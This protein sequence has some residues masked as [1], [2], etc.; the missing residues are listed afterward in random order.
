MLT[1]DLRMSYEF[2]LANESQA[3]EIAA[4]VNSAY[5]GDHSRHGWTT[6]ADLLGG[7]RTDGDAVQAM[8]VEENSQI[9][10]AVEGDKR[11]IRGCAYVRQEDGR[12]YVGMLT[13]EP[14]LQGRG[15]GRLLLQEIEEWVSQRQCAVTYMSVISK[16]SEL[17]DWYERRGY[18]QTG[19][20][21]EFPYGQ[22]RFGEPEVDDLKLM[23]LEKEL[24]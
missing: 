23:C 19:R 4:L 11:I 14:L 5:R 22:P 2:V 13:V 15:L 10:I 17:I 1:E 20:T 3:E 16:R 21:E 6:E 24:V 7:Q 18:R 12:C 8:L 9:L